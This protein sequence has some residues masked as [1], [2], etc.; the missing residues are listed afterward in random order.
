MI[1]GRKTH[2][3]P[4]GKPLPL[5]LCDIALGTTVVL[6]LVFSSHSWLRGLPFV[7]LFVALGFAYS[8]LLSRYEKSGRAVRIAQRPTTVIKF[9]DGK[10]APIRAMRYTYFILAGLMI[11]FGVAPFTD[12]TARIGIIACVL[13][14]FVLA[15]AY[16][17]LEQHYVS[18]GKAREIRRG[19]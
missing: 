11:L 17:A 2:D 6:W 10:P 16:V 1:G 19:S 14:L 7:G 9:V 8:N 18:T 12:R 15:G 13:A 4:N 3:Y 5:W